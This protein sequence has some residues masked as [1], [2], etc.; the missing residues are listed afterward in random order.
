[1]TPDAK[2]ALKSRAHALKPVVW[3]GHQGLT[4]SVLAEIE[5]ALNT[6]ELIKVKIPGVEKE[7]RQVT[8]AQ[9]LTDTLAELVQLMGQIATFYRKNK[10]VSKHKTKTPQKKR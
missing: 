5:L 8:V 3:L 1:M 10:D 7:A 2:K 6:H 4:P 9:I